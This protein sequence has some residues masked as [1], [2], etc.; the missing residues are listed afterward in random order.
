MI[1]NV[2]IFAAGLAVYTGYGLSGLV[3]LLG[4]VLISYLS[5][6]WTER[7]RGAAW[8]GIGIN[9]VM[10]TFFKVQ[11]MTGLNLAAPLGVS[12]FTLML[13]AYNADVLMGKYPAERNL[14]R[15]AACLTY[16]PHLLLGPIEGYGALAPSLFENRRVSWDGIS[17]GA[18]RFFWGLFKKLVVAARAGV[19]VSAISA[20]PEQHLSSNPLPLAPESSL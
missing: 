20:D 18:A 19:I 10:L 5:A 6:L 8:I 9:A 11:H 2:L 7:F 17:I 1:G 3:C 15:F 13:I 14:I 4:A 16:F 12:Y